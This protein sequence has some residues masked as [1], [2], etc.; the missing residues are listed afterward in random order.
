MIRRVTSWLMQDGGNRSHLYVY[1]T[2]LACV[3]RRA[4]PAL[5]DLLDDTPSSRRTTSRLRSEPQTHDQLVVYTYGV[6]SPCELFRIMDRTWF[7]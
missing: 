5:D 6:H 1:T 2:E 7:H 3:V 4:P